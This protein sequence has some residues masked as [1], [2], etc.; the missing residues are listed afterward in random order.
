MRGDGESGAMGAEHV[1]MT[2]NSLDV[3]LRVP[4]PEGVKAH[5]DEH[6]EPR[7]LILVYKRWHERELIASLER[8][9]EA[10]R[11]GPQP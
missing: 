10:I 8:T 6:L 9:I 3:G 4:M 2:A 5:L 7:C 1:G 11:R